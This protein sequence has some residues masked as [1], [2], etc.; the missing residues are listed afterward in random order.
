MSADQSNDRSHTRLIAAC[1]ATESEVEELQAYNENLFDL[2]KLDEGL[3]FPLDDEPFV[4]CWSRWVEEAQ[5]EGA[6]SAL[7][8]YLPQLHFP[9][10]EGVS[11][12]PAYRRATLQGAD[13]AGFEEATGLELEDEQSVELELYAGAAG[14]VPVFRLK[15]RSQFSTMVKA[16]GRRNEPSDI[17]DSMGAL[18]I[19]GFNNWHRIRELKKKWHQQD[20]AERQQ[21]T[22][23]EAFAEIRKHPELYQDRFM[24]LSDGPYSAVP[25]ADLGLE[26]QEW[27]AKSF[28]IR[29]D[30]ECAHYFTRRLF[31][32][33]RNNLLDE[34]IADY[35]GIVA[36]EGRYRADWFL[37]FIG[38]DTYPDY[39]EGGR[40]DLYRGDPPLS[41]GAFKVLHTLVVRAAEHLEQ[42]D[43]AVL[44]KSDRSPGLQATV[45][46]ALASMRIDELASDSGPELLDRRIADLRAKLSA[47]V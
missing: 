42:V 9:I 22:W 11:K 45:I 10:E 30:H 19:V 4:E 47:S 18:M 43:H 8:K 14:R 46:A 36:A 29:R 12:W 32:S 23:N 25:A 17:P 44:P 35:A 31:G 37:R 15:G 21:P 16:L 26:E 27:R 34:L 7:R 20:E 41:D 13:P 24:L 6:I 28:I 33:M 39:R 38:L 1:G 40:L 3:R 2:A 5:R